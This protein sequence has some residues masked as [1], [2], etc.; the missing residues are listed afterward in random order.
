MNRQ[1]EI[2]VVEPHAGYNMP[3]LTKYY[4]ASA[5]SAY[6]ALNQCPQGMMSENIISVVELPGSY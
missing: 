2:T 4:I 3:K 6:A 1:W 5:E